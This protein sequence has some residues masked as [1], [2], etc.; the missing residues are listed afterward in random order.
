M[1]QFLDVRHLNAT[2][3]DE[4]T[5]DLMKTIYCSL[6]LLCVV[7]SGCSTMTDHSTS[8]RD[9]DQTKVSQIKKGVTTAD[10]VV[11]LLGEPDTKAIVSA[12]QVMW[13]YTYMTIENQTHSGM[14]IPT[15]VTTTG[16]RK[17]L[18][19]LLQDD[20]VLNFTYVKVPIQ[21]EKDNSGAV[22]TNGN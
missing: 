10:G 6:F 21:S 2:T 19:I 17:N 7:L 12:N 5:I 16:Y 4:N 11:A 15:V 8:G 14:F 9:F 3:N 13:H 22:W 18:D 20:I 1:A